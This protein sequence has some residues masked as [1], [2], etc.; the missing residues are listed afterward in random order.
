MK[1]EPTGL[2]RGLSAPNYQEGDDRRT[3]VNNRGELLVVQALPRLA[4]LVRLGQS[5][6]VKTET[7]FAALTTEPTTTAA[8]SLFNEEMDTGKAYVIQRVAIWERVVDATQQ[9]QL[10]LFCNIQQDASAT[11]TPTATASVTP[12]GLTGKTYGGSA[13]CAAGATVVSDG[14]FAH[15]ASSPGSAAVAG[16]AWRVTETDLDGYYIV[17]PGGMFSVHVAKIAATA[18]QC[19][20]VIAWHEVQLDCVS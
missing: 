19:H 8:L 4:E 5:W 13:I 15:A 11:V 3:A 9:N 18:T 20:A 16:G 7:A 2:V 10:A 1:T 14:W 12:R 6:Q 17:R